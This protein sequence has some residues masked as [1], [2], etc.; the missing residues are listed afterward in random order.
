[1]A[2]DARLTHAGGR[3]LCRPGRGTLASRRG[4]VLD[5]ADLAGGFEFGGERIPLINPQRGIFK[6]RQMAHLLSIKTV[7]P[8]RGA[9]VWYDDQREAHRQIYA[10]DDAVDY[11]FMG[12]DSNS[13]DNRWLLD[14]MQQQ[15]PVIYFLG[16]SPGRYQPIIPTFIVGWHPERVRVQLAFGA[17]VGASA[18]AVPPDAP[19]R[20]YA[21]RE[22]KARL[23]QASFR[24]V[25]GRRA[26]GLWR[27]MRDLSSTRTSAARCR[28]HRHGRGRA[29]RATDRLEWPA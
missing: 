29:V 5:S 12:T 22:V 2:R 4:G 27:P 28:S 14:A 25:P 18:Q 1:M 23:H 7:F 16:T 13:A 15:I 19:E 21:L 10:G 17:T 3:R 20:R 26:R 8:R 11:Q 9:R 6:P 24:I